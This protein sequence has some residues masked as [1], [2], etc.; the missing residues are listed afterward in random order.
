MRAPAGQRLQLRQHVPQRLPALALRWCA[1]ARPRALAGSLAR[2]IPGPA[3]QREPPPSHQ[4]PATADGAAGCAA[5]EE[6]VGEGNESEA[7]PGP[8]PGAPWFSVNPLPVPRPSPP[9]MAGARWRGRGGGLSENRGSRMRR[10]SRGGGGGAV[11]EEF[12]REGDKVWLEHH[13]ASRFLVFLV[14]LGDQTP[15]NFEGTSY[16][17]FTSY[18]ASKLQGSCCCQLYPA[19]H[20]RAVCACSD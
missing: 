11:E 8:G 4:A 15:Y 5:K 20:H 10:R 14:R 2:L 19:S 3:S 1:T 16:T 17:L 9:L 12:V 7:A 13:P 18:L 6:V